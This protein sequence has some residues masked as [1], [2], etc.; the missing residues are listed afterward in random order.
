MS[1]ERRGRGFEAGDLGS[2]ERAAE[3]HLGPGA[4]RR[5]GREGRDAVQP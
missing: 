4:E 1:E 2:A 5:V 3:P